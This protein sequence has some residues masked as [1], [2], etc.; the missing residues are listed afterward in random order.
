MVAVT[1]STATVIAL[2]L[3]ITVLLYDGLL[4]GGPAGFLAMGIAR[5]L[6]VT[7]GVVVVGGFVDVSVWVFAGPT[8]VTGYITAVTYMDAD[9]A[10]GTDRRAVGVG[11]ADVGLAALAVP[12]LQFVAGTTLVRLVTGSLLTGGFVGW[13]VL[14]LVFLGPAI[15]LARTFDVS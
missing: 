5:G 2:S 3:A 13:A 11:I 15:G 9:E 12:I 1:A 8:I 14:T 4:N 7:L 10:S 6:N